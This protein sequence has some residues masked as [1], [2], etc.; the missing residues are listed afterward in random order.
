MLRHVIFLDAS[1]EAVHRALRD[2]DFV[3]A[4]AP[5][6]DRS[7]LHL[8]DAAGFARAVDGRTRIQILDEDEGV[9][10]ARLTAW[11]REQGYRLQHEQKP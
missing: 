7:L 8:K 9:H 5:G 10:V 6:E 11:L 1:F 2:I 3:A 4:D